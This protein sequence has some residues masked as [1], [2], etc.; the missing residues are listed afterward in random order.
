MTEIESD[1]MKLISDLRDQ[2][3]EL[4]RSRQEIAQDA[5][6]YETELCSIRQQLSEFVD[7]PDDPTWVLALR[8]KQTV[9]NFRSQLKLMESLPRLGN[10]DQQAPV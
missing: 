4:R 3:R 10:Q 5:A 9:S 2:V 8:A 1:P 7:K 6:G